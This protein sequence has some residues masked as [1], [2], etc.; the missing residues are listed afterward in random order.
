MDGDR[1]HLFV[2]VPSIDCFFVAGRLD[3]E[4]D[5]HLRP[6]ILL[7]ALAHLRLLFFRAGFRVLVL[8]S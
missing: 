4:F 6:F 5:F 8:F 2:R 3:R 7:V 1:G